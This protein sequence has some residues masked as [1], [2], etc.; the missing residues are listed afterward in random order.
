M[1]GGFKVGTQIRAKLSRF[2]LHLPNQLALFVRRS[3]CPVKLVAQLTNPLQPFRELGT[4]I[5]GLLLIH[6]GQYGIA[7]VNLS[8]VTIG[9]AGNRKIWNWEPPKV[10]CA[11]INSP[12]F[13][14]VSFCL[15]QGYGGPP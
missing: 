4:L 14:L 6:G 15:R 12:I 8:L 3:S 9:R 5:D 1:P 11:S 10:F 13:S 2:A 7:L